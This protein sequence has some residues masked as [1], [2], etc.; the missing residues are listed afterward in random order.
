M[1]VSKGRGEGCL[2]C[3]CWGCTRRT[4]SK[5]QRDKNQIIFP[6]D[7]FEC[8]GGDV[9]VVEICRVVHYDVLMIEFCVK[10]K[11]TKKETKKKKKTKRN[12]SGISLV[13]GMII[14]TIPM[15][16]ARV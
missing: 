1:F 16:V 5:I 3:I 8:D 6:R 2:G 10:K 9:G 15:P 13:G 7:G 11:K 14:L 4:I 12:T